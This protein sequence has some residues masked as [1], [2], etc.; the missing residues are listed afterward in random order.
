MWKK[1]LSEDLKKEL[2]RLRDGNRLER[3]RYENAEKAMTDV[4]LE[5][6]SNHK[7]SIGKYQAADVLSQYRLF[8]EI[9]TEY[10]VVHFVWINDEDYI[11]D[12][13]KNPDPCYDR[14]KTLISTNKIPQYIPPA[15]VEP[16]FK[17]D[18]AWKKSAMIYAKLIDERGRANSNLSMLLDAADTYKIIDVRADREGVGLEISLLKLVIEDCDNH[19]I[20]LAYDLDLKA[21]IKKID[22]MIQI[23]TQT[24]FAIDVQDED[25]QLWIR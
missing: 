23:L 22:L 10:K 6:N 5:P 12:N 21:D 9:L 15:V 18:G 3:Q 16:E 24:G 14:F 11:H 2:K 4:L 17:L 13:R 25:M 20:K 19:G 7:H 8:Y 1:S